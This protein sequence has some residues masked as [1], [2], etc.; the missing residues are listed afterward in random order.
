MGTKKTILLVDDSESIREAVGF[1]LRQ[2]GYIVCEACSGVDALNFFDGRSFHLLLTD[3]H[4]PEMNGLELISRIRQMN[5]YKYLPVL[6][7]TTEHQKEMIMA[8]KQ[9][10]AT[11]W[12]NKPF[13]QQKLLQ[14]VR[15]L[16]R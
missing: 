7:L 6:V 9:A 5:L 1:M 11:G 8:A 10:G 3:Y 12:L 2:A 4:M 15:R 16:I 14:T 13:E